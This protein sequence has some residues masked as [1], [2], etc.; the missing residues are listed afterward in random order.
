[1]SKTNNA[2]HWLK[3]KGRLESGVHLCIRGS[4]VTG[5]RLSLCR[6]EGAVMKDAGRRGGP[7]ESVGENHTRLG[8]RKLL[9]EARRPP[10]MYEFREFW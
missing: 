5:G 8:C 10:L 1:M 9:G 3:G 2:G 6:A 7:T 4:G